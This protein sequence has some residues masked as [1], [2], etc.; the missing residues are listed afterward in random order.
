MDHGRAMPVHHV[1]D[2]L[3][4]L[5]QDLRRVAGSADGCSSAPHS[6]RVTITPPARLQPT[7]GRAHWRPSFELSFQ[8]QVRWL[9]ADFLACRTPF[10]STTRCSRR[11]T[12]G[13]SHTMGLSGFRGISLDL[14]PQSPPVA[15]PAE[16]V[17][18]LPGS[19]VGQPRFIRTT[20]RSG[21]IVFIR[22]VKAIR[23]VERPIGQ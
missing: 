10:N 16:G 20:Q 12:H 9:E 6:H 14:P 21:T 5:D 3:R 7:L 11:R 18:G 23:R 19:T 17:L 4:D 2:S 1:V 13:P 15:L 8:E 22:T